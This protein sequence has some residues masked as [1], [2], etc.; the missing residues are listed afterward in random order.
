MRG[1]ITSVAVL[2]VVAIGLA[3]LFFWESNQDSPTVSAQEVMA[4]AC[5]GMARL[6]SYDMI[7]TMKVEQDG[8][9][10]DG[11]FTVKTRLAGKDF[12]TSFAYPDGGVSEAIRVGD[13]DYERFTPGEAGWRVSKTKFT[14]LTTHLEQL[15][16]SPLCP[17]LSE[18]TQ[19]GEEQ[20]D[21]VKV[22]VY[23][24]GDI[25]GVEKEDLEDLPSSFK[26]MKH[27]SKHKYW[28]NERGLL[29]QHWKDLYT[30]ARAGEDST[31]M[32][33]TSTAK[34]SS[35]GEANTITAPNVG[36]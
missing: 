12:Q 5:E 35:V 15:G 29:V 1:R 23:T 14:D 19:K 36:P 25:D 17:D 16:V 13:M 30:F 6:D 11:T 28:V 26:G 31:M 22:T 8:V 7:V 34:F 10:I 18:V 27:A 20:L 9:P 32:R 24:A 3:S 4:R 2:G 33:F 21:G